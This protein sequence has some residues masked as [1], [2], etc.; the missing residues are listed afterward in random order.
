MAIGILQMISGKSTEDNFSDNKLT[1]LP[2]TAQAF[3]DVK[4]RIYAMKVQQPRF[5]WG[6]VC[7]RAERAFEVVSAHY[8]LKPHRRGHFKTRNCGLTMGMGSS[9]C[10][11]MYAQQPLTNLL[12]NS[13]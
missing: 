1:T 5:E 12:T 3:G 6:K 7:L 9:V 2:S 11:S 10:S 13:F 4:E 8:E